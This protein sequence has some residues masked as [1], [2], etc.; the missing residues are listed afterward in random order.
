MIVLGALAAAAGGA[1]IIPVRRWLKR[2]G[3]LT[4]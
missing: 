3:Q 4:R 2:N 1:S